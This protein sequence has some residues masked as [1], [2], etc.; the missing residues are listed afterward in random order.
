MRRHILSLSSKDAQ[1]PRLAGGKAAGLARLSALGY[2]V[3]PGFVVTTAALHSHCRRIMRPLQHG[4]GKITPSLLDEIR[5]HILSTPLPSALQKDIQAACRSYPGPYAVRSSMRGEDSQKSSFAGLLDT[6]LNVADGPL[7]IEAVRE[8]LASLCNW[9]LWSYRL[10]TGQSWKIMRQTMAT[11][12]IV[13]EMIN[14]QVSGVAFGA[15]PNTGQKDVI[16]EAV[17]G[18]GERLVQGHITPHRYILSDEGEMEYRPS[19]EE[20]A[21]CLEE[22]DVLRLADTVLEISARTGSP[23]DIEWAFD[24]RDF[25]F[26]Q[27]RPITALPTQRIYSSRLVSEMSPGLIKP[28][29]WSTKT[30]SMVR[31]VFGRISTEL[32]GP[33]Q[34][35]FA[36]YI[37]RIH[38]RLYADMTSFGE[39]LEQLGLPRN[40]FE[41][42]TR[43]EK[44]TRP[45][46]SFRTIK[47]AKRARLLRF[48][49]RYSRSAKDI[50][51][52]IEDHNRALEPFR[53]AAWNTFLPE[54]LLDMFD[55]LLRLH[56]KTQ[57]FIFIG[58]MNMTIR[59]RLLGRF[60]ARRAPAISPGEVLVGIDG[61]KA[62]EPNAL[63]M[64]MGRMAL[65][66]A[67]E[68]RELMLAGASADLEM[69]LSREDA[70]RKLLNR[71]HDFMGRY[72]FLSA[73]GS[74]FT[75]TPWIEDPD[76]IWRAI[77]RF[78]EQA[79]AGADSSAPPAQRESIA[80]IRRRLN[81]LHRLIFGRL[82]DS[83]RTYVKLR[84][85]SSLI[86]S[87]ETYLM[88]R[89]L[90]QLGERLGSQGMID[91]AADIF[92]LYYDELREWLA[93]RLQGQ[94]IRQQIALRKK[95][96]ERD[97]K[98]EVPDTFQGGTGLFGPKVTDSAEFLNG[99][100]GSP[101]LAH[102]IAR[103]VLNPARPPVPLTSDDIL[104]VPF[105]DVGWTPLLPGIRGIVAETGGQLSHTSIIA[106]E[107]GLPAV[108]NVKEA[109]RLIRDGEL[110]TIDGTLGKVY[111][112]TGTRIHSAGEES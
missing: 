9:R 91:G 84:E 21:P 17:R 39:L 1:D 53:R 87:E 58:P 12:V 37:K 3:P 100:S 61:L 88:R 77:G 45:A 79:A 34:V 36:K 54:K 80:E 16:I 106:R 8:C 10:E 81:V 31:T 40:F 22:K 83:T 14:A 7:V 105:T 4:Q 6:F 97:S 102:G 2:S 48:A 85:S 107:Y 99:I 38:S 95:E 110:I 57:W 90:M 111:R 76:S 104:V 52:F 41:M 70:G 25:R 71:F 98:I 86:M 29:M 32:V 35:D 65:E 60:L 82:L 51:A 11:A 27:C 56:A 23:Q 28:L 67:P 20:A 68:T 42:I 49:W 18:T 94:N 43:H 89:A 96:M 26:L 108:V 30:R 19:G 73:N 112:H 13:Q 44:G 47:K 92:Y 24:G 46:F 50:A 93:G 78:A 103:I 72:G 109:T 55:E 62:L 15:D 5:Q 63:L 101:G 69:R 75:M 74:D 64:E 66:L 59:Y 33:N